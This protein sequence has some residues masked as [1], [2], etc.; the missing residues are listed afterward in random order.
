MSSERRVWKRS[1]IIVGVDDCVKV[2]STR[3][4]QTDLSRIDFHS[5]L[6]SDLFWRFPVSPWFALFSE[7]RHGPRFP[8]DRLVY[9]K[10]FD[11]SN[12]PLLQCRTWIFIGVIVIARELGLPADDPRLRRGIDWLHANQRENGKWFTRSPV[13]EASNLIS[14][15]GSAFAILALQACSE[16]PGGPLGQ[17]QRTS[18]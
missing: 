18:R 2:Y 17:S 3:V 11:D 4:E 1:T 7:N 6:Q 12:D 15:V 16:L 14:N 8:P 10:F 9:A 13:N 5:Q